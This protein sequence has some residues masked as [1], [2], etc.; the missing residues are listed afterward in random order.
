MLLLF[1]L[2]LSKEVETFSSALST[3]STLQTA[4][5][6]TILAHYYLLTFDVK[7]ARSAL[8]DE[9]LAVILSLVTALIAFPAGQVIKHN[10]SKILDKPL[11]HLRLAMSAFKFSTR[12]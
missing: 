4:F 8:I 12:F 2:T 1:A 3:D 10:V 11:F 7:F 6:V 5:T 9:F